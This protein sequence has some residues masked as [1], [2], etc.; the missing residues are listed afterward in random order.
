MSE[1]T[2]YT[3]GTPSWA[4]NA[5]A[6]PAK[7]AEFYSQLFGWD[8]ED[9]MPAEADGRYF[10]ARLRG[11]DVAALGSAP[12][13][14]MPAVWNTYVTVTDVE[15]TAEKVKDAGGTVMME[16]FDVFDAGRM[17]VF[18]DPSGAV[19]MAWKPNQMIGAYIVNEPNTLCWNEL[20][21]RDVEGSREF[22]GKVFGWQTNDMDFAG[23]KY[24]VWYLP[25]VDVAEGGG[26]GGMME[27]NEQFPADLPPHWLVYFAVEDTDATVAK[28]GELGGSTVVEPFDAE[29]VGRI[30]VVSDPNGAAFAAITVTPP[31]EGGG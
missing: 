13:E 5:S 10:M 7:A 17:A 9:V 4:D 26:I 29:G 16:P 21:T 15:E 20:A 30:A 24:T 25:G 12:Q 6:D 11:K 19:F 8:T 27:M 3:P 18:A 31:P 2:E 22:Y 1:R 28:A 23:G 14:G